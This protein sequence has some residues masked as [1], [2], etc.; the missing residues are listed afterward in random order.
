M[1]PEQ[2]ERAT[3]YFVG[4]CENRASGDIWCYLLHSITNR[5][6]QLVHLVASFSGM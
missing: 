4:G 3:H 2:L 5:S 1:C 6:Q